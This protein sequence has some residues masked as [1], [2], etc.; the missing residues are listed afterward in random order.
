MIKL[1]VYEMILFFWNTLYISND[2]K[3]LNT[4]YISNYMNFLNS[5]YIFL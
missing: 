5:L 1:L 4:Q 2:S 3:F